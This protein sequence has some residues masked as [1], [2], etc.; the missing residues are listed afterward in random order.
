[1]CRGDGFHM[2]FSRPPQIIGCGGVAGAQGRVPRSPSRTFTRA[3]EGGVWTC[4]TRRS[5]PLRVGRGLPA[6]SRAAGG[7]SM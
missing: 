5:E 6:Y 2:L 1:M 7:M 4:G 3:Y